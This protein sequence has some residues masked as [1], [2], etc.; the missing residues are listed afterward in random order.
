MT[1]KLAIDFIGIGAPKSGTTWLAECLRQHPDVILPGTGKQGG[2][3]VEF[4][5]IKTAKELDFFTHGYAHGLD[6]NDG[7]FDKGLDWYLSHFAPAG[8]G[9]VRGEISP[10]YLVDPESAGLVRRAYPAAKLLAILRDPADTVYSLYWFVRAVTNRVDVSFEEC[11]ERGDFFERGRH[12]TNLRRYLDL[13]PREQLHLA[14]YDDIR[15]RPAEMIAEVYRFLGV[16]DDFRPTSLERRVNRAQYV[17]SAGLR[18]AAKGSMALLR[19]IGLRP[20]ADAI[21]ANRLVYDLYCRVNLGS[22]EYPPMGE[23]TR[24][25]LKAAYRDEVLKLQELIGRDLGAWL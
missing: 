2:A 5:N 9:Q 1:G 18:D 19:R 8:P 10:V 12:W 14:V 3:G 25:R 17:K 24:R 11:V 6:R 15:T 22:G 7:N 23:E 13:F 21:G 20:L 16:R 4:R